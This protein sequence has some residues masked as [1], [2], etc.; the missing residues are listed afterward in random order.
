MVVLK[1]V[2]DLKYLEIERYDRQIISGKYVRIHQEDFC[3]V[4]GV[5]SNKKYQDEGGPGIK[6]L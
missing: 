6:M 4:L 5:L 1:N 3:Q 2:L